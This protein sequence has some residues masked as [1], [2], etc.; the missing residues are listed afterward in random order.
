M[1]GSGVS[2]ASVGSGAGLAGAS[3]GVGSGATGG[4]LAG[5]SMVGGAVGVGGTDGTAVGPPAAGLHAAIARTASSEAVKMSLDIRSNPSSGG[6]LGRST[7][8]TLVARSGY[9]TNVRESA[10][11]RTRS[12]RTRQLG[13]AAM[14]F[15]YEEKPSR[16]RFVDIIWRTHDTSDGTYLAAAD[17]CWD[18][19]FIRSVHGNRVAPERAVVE[20]HAGPL[21]RRQPQ[22]RDPLPPRHVPDPRAHERDG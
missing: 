17:A 7:G 15:E 21:S 3:V 14:T 16:S 5:G 6:F 10:A 22:R 2:G 4:S 12:A 18:M 13:C 19:I 11:E 8:E 20:D 1:A 9:G